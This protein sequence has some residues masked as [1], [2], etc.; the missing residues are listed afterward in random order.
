MRRQIF[1]QIALLAGVVFT[2]FDP[3][4]DLRAE[5]GFFVFGIGVSN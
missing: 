4:V 2:L 1:D 5:E 3:T